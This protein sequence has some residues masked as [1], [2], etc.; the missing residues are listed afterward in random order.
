MCM[1]CACAYI[2]DGGSFRTVKNKSWNNKLKQELDP[3]G[4]KMTAEKLDKCLNLVLA[5]AS[6]NLL[7]NLLIQI[8]ELNHDEDKL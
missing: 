2:C 7:Q 8:P 5:E 4:H 1:G 3:A 6:N